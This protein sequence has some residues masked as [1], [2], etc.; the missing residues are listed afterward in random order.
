MVVIFVQL[1]SWDNPCRITQLRGGET[2]EKGFFQV[3]EHVII[4][5]NLGTDLGKIVK[6][7]EESKEQ[8]QKQEQGEGNFILR[9]CVPDDMVKLKERNKYKKE[10]IKKCEILV[11]KK[12][13]P[14]KIIDALFSF[15]GSKIIFAFTASTRIDFRDLVKDLVQKFH[16]SIRIHQVGVRQETGLMGDIGPCGRSLCCL[17]FL[18]NL[19]HVTTEMMF[20]QQLS[21]RGPERL[22]GI[23]GRLKCCLAFENE[24]YKKLKETLPAIGETVKTKKGKGK[25]IDR[26]VLKQT[27][28]IET[29][30]KKDKTRIEVPLSEIEPR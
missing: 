22:S 1:S 25:V 26:H 11:K 8:E 30:D 17:S 3:G 29:G 20:D 2:I 16:K 10:A 9:K 28:V 24:M 21:Q 13:L 12:N 5:T 6:I 15:D 19:G 7:E 4:K 27:V 14:M 18:K 23:C